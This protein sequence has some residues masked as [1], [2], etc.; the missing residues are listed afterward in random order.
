MGARVRVC[1]SCASYTPKWDNNCQRHAGKREINSFLSTSAAG[2]IETPAAQ[3]LIK[4]LGTTTE[5]IPAY[6]SA[7]Q[8]SSR[9]AA[10]KTEYKKVMIKWTNRINGL[11]SRP[12]GYSL[13]VINQSSMCVPNNT[14]NR[15]KKTAPHFP[16]PYAYT[17]HEHLPCSIWHTFRYPSIVHEIHHFHEISANAPQLISFRQHLYVCKSKQK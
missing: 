13:W 10:K 14:K 8:T 4:E 11:H 15:N 6:S 7:K 3:V 17:E 16:W 5:S 2:E 1:F 12:C 9:V